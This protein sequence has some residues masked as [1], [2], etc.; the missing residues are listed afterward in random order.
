MCNSGHD[1]HHKWWGTSFDAAKV[2]ELA[3][4]M[5][6]RASFVKFLLEGISRAV[7]SVGDEV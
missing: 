4:A 1:M 5:A 6:D 7:K 2:E 3:T